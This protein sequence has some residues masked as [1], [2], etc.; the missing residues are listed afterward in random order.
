MLRRSGF[1]SPTALPAYKLSHAEIGTVMNFSSLRVDGA[2]GKIARLPL[3]LVPAGTVVPVLQGKLKGRKW[4]AGSS[5]HGCWLGSYEYD[6]QRLFSTLVKPGDVVFDVGSHVGFYALL[7][8]VLVGDAGK[9]IAFEPLPRNLE[10][11]RKHLDINRV[12]NVEVVEAAVS[13]KAGSAMFEAKGSSYTGEISER[14]TVN[15]RLVQLD[16]LYRN[17]QIP[18][19]NLIKI[20]VEGAEAQV[21]E[22][23]RNILQSAR[24]VLLVATHGEKVHEECLRE[25]RSLGY[26]ISSLDG[27]AVEETDELLAQPGP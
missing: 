10:F 20:D 15:V 17:Q 1:D 9:V 19:P 23:C 12:T 18:L 6:K 16:E 24:P 8:S 7:S 27:K 5:N 2:F 4:I 21:L 13:N 26:R 14:G 22:G 3:K 11:L 25:L